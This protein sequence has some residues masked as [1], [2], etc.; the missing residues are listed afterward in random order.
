MGNLGTVLFNA[1]K[2][3]EAEAIGRETW[4]IR[5]RVLGPEHPAT[6]DAMNNLAWIC[7]RGGNA[8]REEAKTL[9]AQ[10]IEAR[11]RVSGPD[12]PDAIPT[13]M[14]L[15]R[16]HAE[17][18]RLAEAEAMYRSVVDVAKRVAKQGHPFIFSAQSSLGDILGRQGRYHEAEPLLRESLET[19]ERFAPGTWRHAQTQS[20]LGA[21]LV[22]LKRFDEA[23]ALLLA[24]HEALLA[25]KEKIPAQSRDTMIGEAGER[26]DRLYAEWNR[27]EKAQAWR[28][29]LAAAQHQEAP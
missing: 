9:Y 15:G 11:Q 6:L 4:E 27:P 12:H 7:E 20:R 5:K 16:L 18:Y 14:N 1:G 8:G 24:G 17:D 29:T 19:Q 26:V 28:D 3:A 25:L 22:G 21:V 23:E 2:F 13:M 10:V